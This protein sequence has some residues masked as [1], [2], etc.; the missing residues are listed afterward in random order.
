VPSCF[1][2]R[3]DLETTAED[4]TEFL[5]QAGIEGVRCTKLKPKQVQKYFSAAFRASCNE[6]SKDVFCNESVWPAGVELRGKNFHL[7]D[8]E[9]NK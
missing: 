4:L 1:V 5:S 8:G 3:L 6:S 9:H 7:K 2:G